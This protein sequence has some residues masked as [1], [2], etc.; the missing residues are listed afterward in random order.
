MLILRHSEDIDKLKHYIVTVTFR[1]H[2][3]SKGAKWKIICM[4]LSIIKNNCKYM[5]KRKR[6]KDIVNF[7]SKKVYALLHDPNNTGINLE[8]FFFK[9]G[10]DMANLT[11][12]MFGDNHMTR[13]TLI[14]PKIYFFI[15]N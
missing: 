6:F 11:N 2:P 8:N 12:S 10:R 15:R 7:L 4:L 9:I 13:S 14:D 5:S 1:T 3:S